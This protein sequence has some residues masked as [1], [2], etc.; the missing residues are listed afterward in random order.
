MPFILSS[1]VFLSELWKVLSAWEYRWQGFLTSWIRWLCQNKLHSPNKL[2]VN[3]LHVFGNSCD[4]VHAT[5]VQELLLGDPLFCSFTRLTRVAESTLNFFTFQ[6]R[7]S[8]ISVLNYVLFLC[9]CSLLAIFRELVSVFFFVS[10]WLMIIAFFM[11]GFV[12]ICVNGNII[13]AAAVRKE[14]QD[15][16]DR[17]TGRTKQISS[18]PI[19]LSIYSPNG[20][21]E[22]LFSSLSSVVV[23]MLSFI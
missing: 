1:F 12:F 14:I 21:F 17:E 6:G 18:V 4:V 19:H 2:Y 16:T 3:C 22:F 13:Y 11:F 9:H 8:P 15:E 5:H 7:G 10:R 23:H 20:M